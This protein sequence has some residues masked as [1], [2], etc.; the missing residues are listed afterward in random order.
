MHTLGSHTFVAPNMAVPII[1]KSRPM[2][3]TEMRNTPTSVLD[4]QRRADGEPSFIVKNT[5]LTENQP[6]QLDRVKSAPAKSPHVGRFDTHKE[7]SEWQ[8]GTIEEDDPSDAS[9][10]S[11]QD[12]FS[13]VKEHSRG[14]L[15]ASAKDGYAPTEAPATS[16]STMAPEPLEPSP[17]E[18][19]RSSEDSVTCLMDRHARENSCRK[20]YVHSGTVEVHGRKVPVKMFICPVPSEPRSTEI[21]FHSPNARLQVS[22][23]CDCD[24]VFQGLVDSDLDCM[25]I[26]FSIGVKKPGVEKEV[27]KEVK[28]HTYRLSDDPVCTHA[29]LV[30]DPPDKDMT[31]VV[32]A[33]FTPTY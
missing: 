15:Q 13:F 17:A 3:F 32:T 19:P 4:S 29:N 22:V 21:D 10:T 33:R 28:T 20:R 25:D 24:N 18:P 2:P 16:P 6:S 12:V 8:T 11:G 30:F 1:G 7:A 27:V 9:R 31:W 5:F 14:E 23:R 26:E